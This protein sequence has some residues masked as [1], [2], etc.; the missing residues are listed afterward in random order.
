MANSSGQHSPRSLADRSPGSTE[1]DIG[2]AS[3]VSLAQQYSPATLDPRLGR[4]L[5]SL[6]CGYYHY[7][8]DAWYHRP[9]LLVAV[10]SSREQPLR[11]EVSCAGSQVCCCSQVVSVVVVERRALLEMVV[12]P[13]EPGQHVSRPRLQVSV[14]S[15]AALAVVISYTASH[16]VAAE[17]PGL[18]QHVPCPELQVWVGGVRGMEAISL[19]LLLSVSR[20]PW[21]SGLLRL[22]GGC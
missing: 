16:A 1:H 21:R 20:S 14:R 5:I 11:S 6:C 7:R 8:S 2:R 15:Q 10:A 19:P 13:L 3:R 17:S 9:I 22:G 18:G 4:V 12:E